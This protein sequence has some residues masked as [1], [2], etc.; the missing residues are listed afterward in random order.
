MRTFLNWPFYK[1]LAFRANGFADV[2][3]V[4]G[5]ERAGGFLEWLLRYDPGRDRDRSKLNL[6]KVRGL[7]A[8]VA[9]GLLRERVVPDRLTSSRMWA[10]LGEPTG[11]YEL[12]GFAELALYRWEFGHELNWPISERALIS[13]TKGLDEH[14][15][16]DKNCAAQLGRIGLALDD[17]EMVSRARSHLVRLLA[18]VQFG[19][20]ERGTL[21]RLQSY[22]GPSEGMKFKQEGDIETPDGPSQRWRLVSG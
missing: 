11:P 5:L 20:F 2:V 21:E 12:P 13:L 14:A 19:D 1:Q 17:R 4:L 7:A 22:L 15:A 6:W 9:T 18:A 10:R 8:I 3:R 16:S